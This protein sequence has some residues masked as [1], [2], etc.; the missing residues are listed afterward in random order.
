ML[1]LSS[2]S[3]IVALN[4]FLLALWFISSIVIVFPPKI[5]RK[6]F[7]RQ[8]LLRPR[9]AGLRQSQRNQ[10]LGF[11]KHSLDYKIGCSRCRQSIS[12]ANSCQGTYKHIRPLFL[13]HN[14]RNKMSFSYITP[15]VFAPQGGTGTSQI[16]Y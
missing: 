10:A 1:P 11:R 6:C 8:I 4:I 12:L 9:Q 3:L 15:F 7:L 2:L 13:C 14:L 16:K 5:R